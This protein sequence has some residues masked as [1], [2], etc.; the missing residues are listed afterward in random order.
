MFKLSLVSIAVL[1]IL[2]CSNSSNSSEAPKVGVD[3]LVL[4]KSV[5]APLTASQIEDLKEISYTSRSIPDLSLYLYDEKESSEDKAD[6]LKKSDDM[7]ADGKALLGTIQKDCVINRIA[8][9]TDEVKNPKVGD[10]IKTIKSG[11]VYGDKCPLAAESKHNSTVTYM[12]LNSE[13]AA[14]DVKTD[15]QKSFTYKQ[16]QMRD[17][18]TLVVTERSHKQSISGTADINF[19]QKIQTSNFTVALDGY[20]KTRSY[21][22]VKIT[23][24]GKLRESKAPQTTRNRYVINIQYNFNGVTA[25]LD[26]MRDTTDGKIKTEAYLNGQLLTKTQLKEIFNY[27]DETISSSERL[28]VK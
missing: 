17:F 18:G 12:V 10:A 26:M 28:G 25:Y 21:G 1:T 5:A 27:D 8:E 4:E 24:S 22:T 14:F 11:S 23:M 16:K 13:R 2:S 6:R 19:A 7:N 3:D 9:K 15:E 20:E